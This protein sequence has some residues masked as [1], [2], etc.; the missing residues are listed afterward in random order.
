MKNDAKMK[1]KVLTFLKNI[2]QY[3]L[4][5]SS[6]LFDVPYYQKSY[7]AS[8]TRWFHPV[9]HYVKVGWMEGKN[10][11]PDFDT[12]YYIRE[13]KDIRK[14]KLNPL[15]H[16]IQYGQTEGRPPNPSSSNNP[17]SYHSWIDQYD[18]LSQSDHSLIE[19]HIDKFINQPLIS[20]L[21]AVDHP[22]KQFIMETL[23][24]LYAQIYENWE[25]CLV[26]D[27][28]NPSI[29]VSIEEYALADP[30]IKV[31]HC[32]PDGHIST[33]LNAAL[34]KAEGSYIGLLGQDDILRE[35]ALYSVV[36]EI[37]TYPQAEI[38]Y[39]DEDLIDEFSVRYDPYFKP[40]WNPDLFC[41][42][43]YLAHFFVIRTDS[44]RHSGGFRAEYEGAQD[45]DLGLRIT[46]I[47]P[48][49]NI[50]HIPF[51]LY[52]WRAIIGSSTP[53]HDH[54]NYTKIAQLRALFSHFSRIE[55]P[56]RVSM[57]DDEFWKIDHIIGE[58]KPLASIII[59]TKNQGKHL[60]GC[61]NS[62]N[63]LT[64]YSNYEI[65]IINNQ[66][67]DEKTLDFLEEMSIKGEISLL[68]YDRPF[69][70]S[71]INNFAVQ[72]VQGDVLVFLNNDTEVISP[73]WLEELIGLAIRPETGA[74]G[75]M[76]YYPNN[77]IQHAGIVLGLR[78]VA[79]HI[80]HGSPLGTVG[81][82]GRVCLAQNLTAVTGACMAITREKFISI[83]GFNETQ[84]GIAYNDIDLC[85]RLLK[86]GYR[87][88]WTPHAEL[89]HYESLS[90]EY[91]NTPE[92]L[93]RFTSEAEYLKNQYREILTNDPAYNLN[94]TL[95]S[96][97][98]SLSF[99]PRTRKPWLQD[100]FQ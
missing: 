57:H 20:I 12:V 8:N 73:R 40:D 92:K 46:E 5:K 79:G 55:R 76:L 42:H 85:I 77:K 60:K 72:H 66:S 53:D 44:V 64:Q 74:V 18:T 50:R 30:R 97:D 6:G 51:I 29:S 21:M 37:N 9:W 25:C 22:N 2:Q 19:K 33:S 14:A 67:D 80:H 65:V 68:E 89:F 17:N 47:I 13:N 1:S 91:E 35:H 61:L 31:T 23:D 15:V 70:Y 10:P 87:N 27:A 24:S 54:D 45:W 71:A 38:I 28:S 63:N 4:I 94:L 86:A 11:S 98:F 69:N 16:F 39:S 48:S 84:L 83:G 81:Q 36:N 99:P 95:S 58:P 56:V 41:G 49:K 75:A 7:Q 88:V 34:S 59:P 93:S 26:Y 78:G 62:I 100:E 96:P 82:R 32:E 43:N 3:L 52:H 90:R